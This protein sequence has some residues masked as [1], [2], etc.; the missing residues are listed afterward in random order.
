MIWPTLR[1]TSEKSHEYLNSL[2]GFSSL[3]NTLLIKLKF[4]DTIIHLPALSLSIC[5]KLSHT[6]NHAILMPPM[7]ELYH[8]KLLGYSLSVT[9]NA[10]I[11]GIHFKDPTKQ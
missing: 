2:L 1:R 11:I 5:R 3:Y 7:M 6:T 9:L 4:L 10:K 8:L